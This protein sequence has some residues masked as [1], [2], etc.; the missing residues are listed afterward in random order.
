MR[1]IQ[2][3]ERKRIHNPQVGT[4]GVGCE[5][6]VRADQ[7]RQLIVLTPAAGTGA[8]E[9]LVLLGGGGLQRFRHRSQQYR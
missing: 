9:K 4:V 3:D 8:A 5:T 2:R 7:S 6:L 1:G